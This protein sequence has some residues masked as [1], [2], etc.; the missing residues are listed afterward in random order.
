MILMSVALGSVI[1]LL[2]TE[3]ALGAS[4]IL[5]LRSIPLAG[6]GALW[7]MDRMPLV[8]RALFAAIAGLL[9]DSMLARPFGAYILLFLFLSGAVE[10]LHIFFS[11][12]ES[13]AA[14]ALSAAIAL[15]LFFML[16]PAASSVARI[17]QG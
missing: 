11:A 5:F 12:R 2:A 3:W 14:R 4:G 1:A 7:W 10:L 17:L 16:L 9:M 13:R 6:F 8:S 15:G